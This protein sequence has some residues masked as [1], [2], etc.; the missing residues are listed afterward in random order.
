MIPRKIQWATAIAAGLFLA[1]CASGPS[2]PIYV[3]S[4]Q[5]SEYDEAPRPPRTE[6]SEQSPRKVLKSE[7]PESE[8]EEAEGAEKLPPAPSYRDQGDALSPAAAS[9]VMEADAMMAQGNAEGALSRLERAQRISPRSAEIY[10]KLSRA[11]V[12]MDQLGRAEQFARK[13]LSLA[14]NN[15]KQQR[16]GW[17]LLAGIRRA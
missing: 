2:G 10:Y 4:E 8:A 14:G 5:S 11:Y 9:L 7:Q 15:A 1:G 17:M 13:G 12:K 16:Q 3:P 6:P